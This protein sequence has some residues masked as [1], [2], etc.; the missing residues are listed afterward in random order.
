MLSVRQL[1]LLAVVTLLPVT[2]FAAITLSIIEA[3][4]R[5]AVEEQIRQSARTA[6]AAVERDM[7][8][9]FAG[10][11]MLAQAVGQGDLA[12]FAAQARR[13]V[14]THPDWL[15]IVLADGQRTLVDTR[16]ADGEALPPAFDPQEIAR[17][18]D[19]G[20]ARATGL[21]PRAAWPAEPVVGLAVPVLREGRV[22]QVLGA[23]L[24]AWT[25]HGLLK[26]H[27]LAE[28]GRIALIDHHETVV[29]RTQSPGPQDLV[30]GSPPGDP[31]LE[32]LRAGGGVYVATLLAG[33]PFLIASAVVPLPG[34]PP[35]AGWT[36]VAGA[37]QRVVMAPLVRS[38]LFL[39]GGGALALVL[40]A[41]F[42]AGLIAAFTRRQ[43][44][45]RGLAALRAEKATERRLADIAANL[46]GIIFRRVL[47]PDGRVSC[48]YAGDGLAD[49]L[50]P[51]P[52]P[53]PGEGTDP[54][55]LVERRLDG[56]AARRWCD[57]V[58]L[59]ART[60]EPLR[61]DAAVRDAGGRLRRIRAHATTGMGEDGAVVWD[62]VLLD[63][64]DQH[65]VERARREGEDRLAFA[66]AFAQAGLWDWSVPG[67]RITWSDSLWPLFGYGR[68]EG[69]PTPE[70]IGR[71]LHPEDRD[72]F[73]AAMRM[74]VERGTPLALEFRVVHPGGGIRWIGA[75]GR[76]VPGDGD[77]DGGGAA[78]VSG[79]YLDITERK[80][81]EEQLH[82]AKEEA[83]RANI[84]KSKFLAAASHDL[85]QPVQSLLFFV[86]IL[87]ERLAG[88]GARDLVGTMQEALDAL[89]LLLDGILDLSKLDA[90]VVVP[91]RAALPAAALLRRLETE[92]APRF[93]GKGLRLT[94]VCPEVMVD[95]DPTLLGRI[96]GNLMENALKYTVRGGVL[97]GARRRGDRLRIEVWDT[98]TGIP[99]GHQDEI[100]EEFVQ[101]G[102]PE[103][104]RNQGLGL[105]LA[106]VK[107]LARLLGHPLTVRSVPGRGSVFTVAVPLRAGGAAAP[108]AAPAHQGA[109]DRQPLALVI[110]D[111]AIILEGLRAMLESWDYRVI[112]ADDLEAA[113]G[114]VAADPRPPDV[115]LADYHLRDGQTGIEAIRA[116]RAACGGGLPA[117]L[118]TGDTEPGLE[119]EAARQRIAILHK[120]V[121][122]EALRRLLEELR[123]TADAPERRESRVSGD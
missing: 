91:Q 72:A 103:R 93:A 122:P 77:G 70:T 19:S 38:R 119:A 55:G 41:L 5:A 118:L 117:V 104:D 89:K 121:R 107:R 22:V 85:R 66:L 4:G 16:A 53:A 88:H 47:H 49:L 73:W 21:L 26:R 81:I 120:P 69:D 80:G 114:E 59:S 97:V 29:A 82:K 24:P 86:H 1:A 43:E 18:L 58:A 57:S 100:F 33:E 62:G 34:F 35:G 109:A 84:A 111:Q 63:V 2:T 45:E 116:L 11:V 87:S 108:A 10:L 20:E 42:G 83:E 64:T 37:P 28:S 68:P 78:R 94:V 92:Y 3:R 51:C 75:V 54:L 61:L 105:G 112:A 123:R 99:S 6:A 110:D 56:G 74:A 101:I 48:P 12:A 96:V 13:A 25:F 60:L 67:D 50:G 95:S 113:M 32:G 65:E 14:Q 90:G 115:L 8:R 7:V 44:A 17:V 30:V 52:E 40:A 15:A 9:E 71:R 31:V 106:I 46:P 76:T 98:G 23:L 39:F 79:L 102:N 27:L 36:V